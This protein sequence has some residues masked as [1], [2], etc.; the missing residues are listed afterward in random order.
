MEGASVLHA[1]TALDDATVVTSGGRVLSV[2]GVGADI[3]AARARA[4]EAAALVHIHGAHH[5][6]DIADPSAW[7][8]SGGTL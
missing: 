5:R 7:A 3:G 1:G 6:S 2:V 8:A 4:Y